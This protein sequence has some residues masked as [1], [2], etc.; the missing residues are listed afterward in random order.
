[1]A[2]SQF[3]QFLTEATT[4]IAAG[5]APL[6]PD[7]LYGLYV[8]WATLHGLAPHPEHNFRNGMRDC[9]VDIRHC[10]LRMTGPAAADYILNS[11]P[12]VA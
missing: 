8:S 5:D 2:S 11:Y 7:T 12:D 10:S 4:D 9:G 3:Q 1:M 6:Q